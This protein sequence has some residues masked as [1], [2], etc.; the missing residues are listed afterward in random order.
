[1]TFTDF[2]IDIETLGKEPGCV[3][4]S[5]GV[6]PFNRL[7][8]EVGAPESWGIDIVAQVRRGF[9]IDADTAL[10]WMRQSEP[11]RMAWAGAKAQDEALLPT[12][13]M[14]RLWETYLAQTGNGYVWANS[15][16]FDLVLLRPLWRETGIQC[17]WTYRMERD[18]RTLG[19][20]FPDVP[21]R[22]PT[23][24]HD[25]ASDAEAQARYVVDCFSPLQSI[26][27]PSVLAGEQLEPAAGLH[28]DLV[29]KAHGAVEVADHRAER[30]EGAC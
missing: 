15:P 22:E 3:V 12:Q 26:T 19:A 8:G 21:R 14:R 10:W 17:P 24:A 25:P 5:I 16:S 6:V 11:A 9:R 30:G 4:L 18:V 1:M 20:V 28:D 7:S 2:M 29:D 13:A 27:Q 23:L